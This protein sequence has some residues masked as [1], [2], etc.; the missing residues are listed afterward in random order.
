MS[1]L[2]KEQILASSSGWVASILNFLPG[3]GTGYIYQRR[4]IPYFLTLG[5]ILSWFV[6]GIILQG[7]NEP[8]QTEKLIGISGL[9]II[10]IFTIIEAKLFFKNSLKI[11]KIQPEQ[12]KPSTKKGWF[13]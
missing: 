1:N 3:A 6:I 13:K 8:S 12:T 7:E 2:S 5:S 9:F 11:V 10:S 4:W